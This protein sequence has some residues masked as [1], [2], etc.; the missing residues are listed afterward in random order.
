MPSV[1][2]PRPAA[3]GCQKKES[4]E[5]AHFSLVIG[6]RVVTSGWALRDSLDNP[7]FTRRKSS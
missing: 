3:L 7:V 1:G 4:G 5:K 6:T 2:L